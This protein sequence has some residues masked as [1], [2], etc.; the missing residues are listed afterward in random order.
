MVDRRHVDERPPG[1]RDVGR[2]PHPLVRDHVLRHLDDDLLSFA[3]KLVDRGERGLRGKPLPLPLDRLFEAV[4]NRRLRE[5]LQRL[6]LLLGGTEAVEVV[7]LLAD[8]GDIEEGVLLEAEVDEGR[9][10]AGKDARDAPLVDVPDD[11][12]LAAALDLHLG[13]APVLEDGHP[14]L[15]VPGRDEKLFHRAHTLTN[16]R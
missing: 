8:V 12:A 13:H 6:G 16:R 9:L 10:H 11:A 14:R 2:D 4:A 7:H 1:K 15:A 3:E 5:A